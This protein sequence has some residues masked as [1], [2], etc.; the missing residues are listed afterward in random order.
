[1]RFRGSS[2]ID[3]GFLEGARKIVVVSKAGGISLG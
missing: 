1:M 2:A 3:R